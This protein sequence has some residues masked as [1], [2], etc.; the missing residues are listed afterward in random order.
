MNYKF[1]ILRPNILY[2]PPSWTACIWKSPISSANFVL[3]VLGITR[4]LTAYV[5]RFTLCSASIEV[6]KLVICKVRNVYL[7]WCK[8]LYT[9]NNS[10]RCRINFEG[11]LAYHAYIDTTKTPQNI[12]LLT[13]YTSNIKSR[14]KTRRVW[15]WWK[16]AAESGWMISCV[17]RIHFTWHKNEIHNFDSSSEE[18]II[19]L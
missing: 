6:Q 19:E 14:W 13:M 2:N 3:N 16:N 7:F 5:V 10:R 8:I 9:V 17:L 4:M 11:Y 1:H 18:N 12:L 15:W